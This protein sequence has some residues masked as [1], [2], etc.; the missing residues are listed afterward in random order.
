MQFQFVPVEEFYFALTLCCK[1]LE[2]FGDRDLVAD[3]RQRLESQF[4]Q[5][6]TVAAS[7]HNSFNYT[8]RVIGVDNAPANQLVISISDWEDKIRISTDYGWI[9]NESRK[10]IRS[11]KFQQREQF[12]LDLRQAIQQDLELHLPD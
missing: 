12:R 5:S 3:F 8:F 11:D 2:K 6:S 1:T 10:P 9:L 4:G 7:K